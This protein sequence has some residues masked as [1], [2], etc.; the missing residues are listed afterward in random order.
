M[1]EAASHAEVQ[2][3]DGRSCLPGGPQEQV[4]HGR[5]QLGKSEGD[6]GLGGVRWSPTSVM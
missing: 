6:S 4:A 5:G 2:V 3:W 1:V